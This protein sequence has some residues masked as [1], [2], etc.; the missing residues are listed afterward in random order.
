LKSVG[1]DVRDVH[2]LS[3]NFAAQI[4]VRANGTNPY[5]GVYLLSNSKGDK[6]FSYNFS[7]SLDKSW[8]NNWAV[9]ANYTFG[10][11]IVINEGT[12]SQNNSQWRFMETVNGRNNLGRSTSDYDPGHRINAYV[13]KKFY[14][15]NKKLATTVSFVYNGQS[16]NSYSYVLNRGLIRDLDNNETNDLI[17]VPTKDQL[18]SM[19]FLSNTTGGVTYTPQQQRDLFDAFIESDKYLKKRRGQYAER[20]GAR[21]PFTHIVDLKL[22]QELNLKLGSKTY[23]LQITYDIF[24]FTNFISRSAGKQY[25]ATND[26]SIILDFTGYVSAAN[27]TPQYRFT[28]LASGRAYNISDG[29]FNSSRWTSQLGIRLSF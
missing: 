9:N 8:N 20:N 1:V 21:T 15:L 3:G 10:N 7:M 25:F 19:V 13:A 16:G 26:Q 23:Q 18:N 6:G 27:L 29:V 22:S 12:S 14:Y 11:S 17:F 5:T 4:P 24:N 28:P 2:S